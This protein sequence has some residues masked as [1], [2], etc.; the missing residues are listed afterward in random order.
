MLPSIRCQEDCSKP[1]EPFSRTLFDWLEDIGIF[2]APEDRFY[3]FEALLEQV[4]DGEGSTKLTWER[5]H[6]PISVSL[7]YNVEEFM[8]PVSSI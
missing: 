6:C 5:K 3:D 7:T 2:T 8:D 4:E 1:L